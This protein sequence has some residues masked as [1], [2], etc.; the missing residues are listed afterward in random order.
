MTK[1]EIKK[2]IDKIPYSKPYYQ[3]SDDYKG[4]L[5]NGL[6]SL[7]IKD[8]KLNEKTEQLLIGDNLTQQKSLFGYNQGI[9]ELLWWFP[10]ERNGIPYKI[11]KNMVPGKDTIKL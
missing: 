6:T 4:K 1:E 5:F 2:I 8:K 9:S 3:K 7:T 10:L 11:E